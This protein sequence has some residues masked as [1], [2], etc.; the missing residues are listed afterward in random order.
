MK[1]SVIVPV[2]NGAPTIEAC[3]ASIAAQTCRD[4]ELIVV[5]DGSTDRTPA[6]LQ[7][8][9]EGHPRMALRILRQENRGLPQ[10]RRAGLAA[11]RGT[12]VMFVDADDWI[13][14]DYAAAMLAAA[15]ETGASM[16][17]SDYTEDRFGKV[18]TLRQNPDLVAAGVLPARRVRL[19]IL[20][21]RAGFQYLW[22]KIFRR[23]LLSQ[24]VFPRGNPIGEDLAV[25]LQALEIAGPVALIP[26]PGYH[27]RVHG[28]NMSR[29]G[30]GPE[31]E[32]GYRMYRD[33]EQTFRG[34][35]EEIRALHRYLMLEY[36]WILISMYRGKRRDAAIEKEILQF[37]RLHRWDYIR[38]SQDRPMARLCA[39]VLCPATSSLCMRLWPGTGKDKGSTEEGNQESDEERHGQD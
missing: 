14:P 27:Y 29:K 16:V 11:A 26:H 12:H 8:F 18:R 39:A 24:L 1:L 15:E 37:V 31:K 21:R 4:Y 28:G 13:E 38:N 32:Q 10:S 17:C 5:D 30:F 3:L 6:L 36:L 2:Y 20:E 23:E 33:L 35:P 34:G 25:V 19:A 9:R 7:A 22:N